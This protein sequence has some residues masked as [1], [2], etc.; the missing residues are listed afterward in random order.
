MLDTLSSIVL[1]SL[2]FIIY[3]SKFYNK[4]TISFNSV[5]LETPSLFN[6]NN[7]VLSKIGRCLTLKWTVD[8]KLS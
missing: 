4:F 7:F 3:L 2:F 8:T 5:Y 6:F 1:V